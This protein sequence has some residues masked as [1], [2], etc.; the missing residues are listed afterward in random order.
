[1]SRGRVRWHPP[2]VECSSFAEIKPV[3]IRY[4]ISVL[5]NEKINVD[6]SLL[7]Y[8]HVTDW[9]LDSLTDKEVTNYDLK[10]WAK[11]IFEICLMSLVTAKQNELKLNSETLSFTYD[12]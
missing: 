2:T 7:R 8:L 6:R 4:A 10:H 3:Q 12:I 9:T 5:A 1:M 11:G